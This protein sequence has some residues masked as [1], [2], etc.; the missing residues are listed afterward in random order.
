MKYKNINKAIVY[1]AQDN[2]FYHIPRHLSLEKHIEKLY[3]L[4]PSPQWD[5]EVIITIDEELGKL[6]SEDL[7]TVCMGEETQAKA[8]VTKTTHDFLNYIFDNTCF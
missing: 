2:G 3:N 8:L 4:F 1:I 6:P 5:E 7:I